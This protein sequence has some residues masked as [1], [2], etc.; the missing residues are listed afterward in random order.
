MMD[1]NSFVVVQYLRWV[2]CKILLAN[3]M[4]HSTLSW[5]CNNA[6][7]TAISEVSVSRTNALVLVG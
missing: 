2:G 7:R 6:A 5:I 4:G 1:S 3:Y